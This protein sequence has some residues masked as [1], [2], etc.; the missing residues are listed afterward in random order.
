MMQASTL[1]K[2]VLPASLTSRG[3]MLQQLHASENDE[4]IKC[5]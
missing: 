5:N 2:A 1:A 3:A 4:K